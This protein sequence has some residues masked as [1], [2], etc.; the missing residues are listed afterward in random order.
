MRKNDLLF[1]IILIPLDLLLIITAGFAA[2]FLR[3]SQFATDIKPVLFNLS[4]SHFFTLTAVSAIFI[5]IVFALSGLYMIKRTTPILQEL[6]K[7]IVSVSAGMAMLIAFM[8]FN[9]EWFD[10]R[11]ILL[12]AWVLSIVFVS[13]GRMFVRAMKSFALR[14]KR[15]GSENTLILG[16]GEKVEMMKRQM[17]QN[18]KLGLNL[19]RILPVP[20]VD[21]LK[22][23]HAEKNLHRVIAVNADFDRQEVMRV[24][25]FCEENGIHFSYVPDM[26]DSIV[27]DMS[28][29]ILEGVPVVSV[30][31]SPLDGWGQAAKRLTDI[32]GALFGLI[33]M[34]PLFIAIAFAIKWDTRGPVL[35]KLKRVSRGKEFRLYKFRS[36]VSNAE[37]LKPMLAHLNEREDGPLFKIAEDP[38]ITKVGKFLR[39]K[40]FD[41]LPQLIN[42]LR[43]EISLVGPRPHEPEEI[44]R[45]K[46]YHKKVLAIKS[47]VTGM[48]QV[49]GASDLPFDEEV[50]LDRFYIENWS[51]KTD[52]VIL[53]KTVKMFLFDKSGV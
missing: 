36:M 7:V 53:L 38:R 24:V 22:N 52:L 33:V 34:S 4:L 51:W 39:A 45:Y 50:K 5:S 37:E 49:S 17:L 3:F 6:A 21:I 48:A 8:F 12:A 13:F 26:F 11:F 42:I 28:F 35:V 15:M 40:R 41:E 19:V 2:Y 1:N 30:R 32:V 25:N 27:A 20:Q 9:R 14:R 46:D 18:K 10:S 44:K 31:P 16:Q 29:D 23:I 47:G 43:G